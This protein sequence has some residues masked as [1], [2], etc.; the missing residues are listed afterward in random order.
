MILRQ[1]CRRI[2]HCVRENDVV[3]RAGGDEFWVILNGFTRP[4]N[5]PA[6]AM[7]M[8]KGFSSPFRVNARNIQVGVSIGVALM[9][10]HATTVEEWVGKSDIALYE[11]KRKGRN[12]WMM[13]DPGMSPPDSRHPL[14]IAT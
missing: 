14:E 12:Q 7:K 1:G 10:E 5:V 11:A 6:I 4:E 8:L 2:A 9:P 3:G 13:F